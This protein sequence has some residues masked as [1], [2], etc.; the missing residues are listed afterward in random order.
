MVTVPTLGRHD[1]SLYLARMAQRALTV[2]AWLAAILILAVAVMSYSKWAHALPDVGAYWDGAAA[3]ARGESPYNASHGVL[4][5]RYIYPPLLATL[6]APSVSV[7]RDFALAVWMAANLAGVALSLM[8]CVRLLGRR[9]SASWIVLAACIGIAPVIANLEEGQTNLWV[10]LLVLLAVE[11]A[12]QERPG[13]AGVLL[14]LATH[15]KVLP[16]AVIVA[17]ALQRRWRSV[18]W[19]GA[20]LAAGVA[21]TCAITVVLHGMPGGLDLWSQV[22][23]DWLRL[24]LQ[25]LYAGNVMGAEQFFI[26]NSSLPAVTHRLFTDTELFFRGPAP[27]PW[28]AVHS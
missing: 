5:K 13:A 22:W 16:V 24:G 2:L 20:A 10:L 1:G 9:L 6:L 26:P 21:A 25:S 8:V 14:G 3:I 27:R 7:T 4:P 18:H 19:A 12:E 15:M 11:A 17:F 23:S 28:R